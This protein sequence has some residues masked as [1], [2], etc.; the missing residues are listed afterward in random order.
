MNWK[1]LTSSKSCAMIL[2]YEYKYRWKNKMHLKIT[3]ERK[4]KVI[5]YLEMS[6]NEKR[7]LHK[8]AF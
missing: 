6:E 3:Q 7:R 5:V 4:F 1:A 8:K 2:C